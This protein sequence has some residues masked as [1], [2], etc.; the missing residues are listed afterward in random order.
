MVE[1]Y[2]DAY[3]TYLQ[4]IWNRLYDRYG[5]YPNSVNPIKFDIIVKSNIRNI[6]IYIHIH[7]KNRLYKKIR[8]FDKM[9]FDVLGKSNIK[10]NTGLH[11]VK[12]LEKLIHE[13]IIIV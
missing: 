5:N 11:L 7:G 2:R 8:M 10:K 13:K 1:L 4:S 12:D 3:Y 9:V 6:N